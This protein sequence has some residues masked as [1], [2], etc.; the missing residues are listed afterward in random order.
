VGP[1][2]L[3]QVR[4]PIALPHK[5]M[6]RSRPTCIAGKVATDPE[7]AHELM[8]GLPDERATARHPF[9]PPPISRDAR[10]SRAGEDGRDRILHGWAA[11]AVSALDKGPFA[12]TVV[13][14]T[15]RPRRT[16]IA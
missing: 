11:R 14:A 6:S 3:G 15:A 5:A 7:L 12:A 10:I 9:R 4:S 8:R 13:C 1:H 2:G 16:L